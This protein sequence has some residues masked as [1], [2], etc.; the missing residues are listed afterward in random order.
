MISPSQTLDLSLSRAVVRDGEA[1][2]V[3][4][5]SL[6]RRRTLVSVY[7]RNNT[8]SCDRQIDSLVAAAGE[9]DRL[10][11]DI[12]A[13]SRDSAASHVKYAAKKKIPFALVSDPD[14]GFARAADAIVEKSMY[15]KT[16]LGPA[17]AAFI[18]DRKG[19]VLAVIERVDTKDHAAQ[20]K[21]CLQG[22]A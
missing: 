11:C 22:L 20:V 18:L 15:G 10:G 14:D 19:K 16:Y 3:A 6:L 4:L 5:A 8:G 21:E 1:N 9:L 13:I 12:I 7:M 17:R 2:T